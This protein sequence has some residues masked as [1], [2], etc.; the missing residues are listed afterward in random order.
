MT[1]AAWAHD[2]APP[3]RALVLASPWLWLCVK[4]LLGKKDHPIDPIG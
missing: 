2:Y 4:I 1:V 3:V